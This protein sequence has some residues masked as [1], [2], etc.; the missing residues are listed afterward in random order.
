M[1]KHCSSKSVA[2]PIKTRNSQRF[3]DGFA[4]DIDPDCNRLGEFNPIP[5]IA[6]RSTRFKY[7][8][9]V[10]FVINPPV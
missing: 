3:Y 8:A 9:M 5:R 1:H 6:K 4:L 10:Q 7:L 2:Y